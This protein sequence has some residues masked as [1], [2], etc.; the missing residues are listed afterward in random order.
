MFN[1]LYVSLDLLDNPG[2]PLRLLS[3]ATPLVDF[4]RQS[5]D[6]LLRVQQKLMI[7]MILWRVFQQ[8]LEQATKKI[9]ESLFKLPECGWSL[10]SSSV[11]KTKWSP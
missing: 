5:F 10:T 2:L 11:A 3:G 8:V 6:V 4:L 7:W 1:S 9:H